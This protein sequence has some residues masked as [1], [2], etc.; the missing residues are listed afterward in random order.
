MIKQLPKNAYGIRILER[1]YTFGTILKKKKKKFC[2]ITKTYDDK[3]LS[4]KTT[5]TF[6]QVC[7]GPLKL[8]F[9]QLSLCLL[10]VR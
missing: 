7:M 8:K 1:E 4:C 5:E 10:K 3:K 9:H 2:N 6:D